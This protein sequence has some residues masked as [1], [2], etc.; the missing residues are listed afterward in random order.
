M[1]E[2]VVVEPTKR[3]KEYVPSSYADSKDAFERGGVGGVM[4][5]W[6]DQSNMKPEQ[7][8]FRSGVGNLAMTG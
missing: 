6:L 7:K 5:H 1:K 8:Q 4:K 2:V 3:S